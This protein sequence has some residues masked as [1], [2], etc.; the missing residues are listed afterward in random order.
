MRVTLLW[1]LFLITQ[2][3]FAQEKMISGV[4]SD[5]SG[6]LPG[7]SIIIEGTTTGV[8]T[9]FDGN[10][11][12]KAKQNDILVFS[13][14]GKATV[15]KTVGASSKINVTLADDQNL[16]NEVV[17][18]A[19]GIKREKKS[20]GYATQEVK[21]DDLSK[22]ATSNVANAIS[23]KV[24]G[25]AI[26]KSGNIGGSTNVVIRGTTSMTGNNQALW[27]VDGVPMNNDN[28]NS[29]EQKTGGSTG[30]YDYGNAAS[31]INPDD[32]ASMSVLKGAAATA[33]YGS[34][35]A[36][37]VIIVTTKKGRVA[38]GFGVT[39][40]SGVTVGSVDKETLPEY[41]KEYGSGW[42]GFSGDTDL[43]SGTHPILT[44]TDAAWGE[45]YDKNLLV[46]NW[47]S[48]YP[49][50]DSYGKAKPYVAPKNDPNSFYNK[51]TTFTNSV[52]LQGST[53]TSSFR[54]GYTKYDQNEGILPNSNYKK[55]N[56]SFSASHNLSEET[57]VNASANYIK[58]DALGLNETGYGAGGNN[59]SSAVRQW[60][61]SDA[62]FETM[63]DAYFKTK[64]NITWNP[65][66][67]NN[68]VP[69]FH[70]NPYFQRYENYNN[71][72]RDRFFGN[73]SINTKFNS[74]LGASARA[75]ID[76]YSQI[77][78]E[79]IAI[80]SKRADNL[81]GQYSRYD[82][83]FREFNMD[84]ILNF[85]TDIT[86][87]ITFTGLVGANARRS[88]NRNIYSVTNGGLSV[89]NVYSLKNS[90]ETPNPASEN[91]ATIGTN[92]AYANASFGFNNT[93]YLEGTFRVDES[94]T[95][96]S[97]NNVYTY[98]S[99]SG[100]YIFS[101]HLKADW[102]SFGK[103]RLNYAETGNDANFAV[104]Q[105]T[106]TK[107]PNYN[108]KPRFEIE[109]TKKNP[110]LKSES[111]SA[112]E[113]GVELK[114]L[115]NRIGLD[116]SAYRTV[117]SDQIMDIAAAPTTG[118]YRYYV[119]A[120]EVENKGLEVGLSLVPVKTEDFTWKA[121]INWSKN[122]NKVRSLFGD[123]KQFE[124][125]RFQGIKSV[126]QIGK[127]LGTMIGLGY[128]RNDKGQP[129]VGAGGY[130]ETVEDVIIG[131][132]NPDWNAGI[133]N[134]FTYKSFTFGFLI[135]VRQ[136]GSVFSLDQKFGAQTGLY[137]DS[138]GNNDLGNPKRD[139]AI[140]EGTDAEKS[141]SGGVINPGVLAD[142]TKNT[143]RVPVEYWYGAS[144][145]EEAFVYDASYV[146][147]REV[148][149]SY[150]IPSK[151]LENSFIKD[152]TL[153]ASASN[154]WIISKELPYADPEATASSGNLQG[155]QTGAMPSTK[156]YNFNV[157]FNF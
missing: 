90:I 73:F 113:A 137:A 8:E 45:K 4:V 109:G 21:G 30:G 51:S 121:N 29:T 81:K 67:Y 11:A 23:G 50:L 7:V 150:S 5:E 40:N 19:L 127:P 94:S 49:E 9:D 36:N 34:R 144:K 124:T 128:K 108:G 155:F 148:S 52:S 55:D 125:G 112:Y 57:T 118:Y 85:N 103:L 16:L 151:H 107:Q 72:N 77:Q 96:P 153:S 61:T 31:D 126:A 63:K 149:F 22:V 135:D 139:A 114:F 95:L 43:G 42:G 39:V 25:V 60:Y 37:G 142:G 92:S 79:R 26:R 76:T 18:T 24:S 111:T 146:K 145:P 78:E 41:Q 64:R 138:A 80:G 105:S 35:A 17:V 65:K 84:L 122:K 120:G 115:Q 38:K 2:V 28:T 62:D 20:L 75:G 58:T 134:S 141:K 3:T 71:Y 106:Y 102:F 98:P 48:F 99:I 154:L 59:L 56:F 10:Y 1:L 69:D 91:L 110:D 97:E 46:Y 140:N 15:Q 116:V 66:S 54:L 74:W 143:K 130:Y 89:P 70:D 33:L 147:L 87:N 47:D 93:F 117:T 100:T 82:K 157:K 123:L 14:V 6:G 88:K 83:T 32:I 86:E 68:R 12:I 44:T 132:A 129:I 131:D 27:V 13:F 136:G 101:K 152:V 133:N 119:N 104:I 53:D 156:E